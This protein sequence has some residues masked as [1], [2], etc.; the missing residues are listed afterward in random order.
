MSNIVTNCID[1]YHMWFV[2]AWVSIVHSSAY[3][4]KSSPLLLLIAHNRFTTHT[5]I[6][7]HYRTYFLYSQTNEKKAHKIKTVK[8]EWMCFVLYS[9]FESFVTSI[10]KFQWNNLDAI[11][12][13]NKFYFCCCWLNDW[14]NSNWIFT[15]FAKS[16][17]LKSKT[18][19]KNTV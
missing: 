2:Q 12:F 18:S 16:D 1:S 5:Y 17:E 19:I 8:W 15:Q 6:H 7:T 11:F 13:W 14:I 3:T 9:Q 4:I 10:S